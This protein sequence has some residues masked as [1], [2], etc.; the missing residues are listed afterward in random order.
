MQQLEVLIVDDDAA[1][2]NAI[3]AAVEASGVNVDIAES[4]SVNAARQSLARTRFDVLILDIALP[5]N[6]GDP[7]ISDGGVQLLAEISDYDVYKKPRYIIGVTGFPN[8]AE[9]FDD[10]FEKRLWRLLHADPASRDWTDSITGFVRHVSHVSSV[11]ERESA[12]DVCLI[13]ALKEPEYDALMDIPWSWDAP[14][15][16]DESTFYRLGRATSNGRTI[17]V[18][19]GYGLRMGPVP[20]AIL[21]SKFVALL[22]P[23]LIGLL[24]ICAGVRGEVNL[25]DVVAASEVW[26]WE[27]GKAIGPSNSFSP[28]PLTVNISDPV[29]ARLQQLSDDRAW[30]DSVRAAYRGTKPDQCLALRIGPVASGTPV[31][32]DSEIISRIR[33]V[34]RKTIGVEMEGFGALYASKSWAVTP[35]LSFF[36]K[37]VCDFADSEKNDSWRDYAA[38]TSAQATKELVERFGSQLA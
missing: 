23:K 5:I 32:A 26:N 11:E 31:I 27:S 34:N 29:L 22:R 36:M 17:S 20:A 12:V 9:L 13:T 3:R 33:S 14:I 38:Y 25:G 21:A 37:S 7:E 6:E 28:E 18:A 4:V 16:L 1:K 19:T 2:R 10:D 35:P 8:I 15:R 30:L 24:G